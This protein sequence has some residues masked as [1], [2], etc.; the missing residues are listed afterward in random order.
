MATDWTKL[1]EELNGRQRTYLLVL[2]HFDQAVERANRHEWSS[3]RDGTPLPA[4]EWRW[5]RYGTS[6]DAFSTGTPAQVTSSLLPERAAPTIG[7]ENGFPPRRSKRAMGLVRLWVRA[8]PSVRALQA[9]QSC[10]MRVRPSL[11]GDG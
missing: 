1:W 3:A 9:G 10:S 4:S 5:I 8:A 2:Y 6:M 11:H 7:T